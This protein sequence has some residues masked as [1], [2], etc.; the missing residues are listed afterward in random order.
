MFVLKMKINN[1][2][3]IRLAKIFEEF[4]KND[5]RFELVAKRTSA[6][7]CFRLKDQS[8]EM[9]EKLMNAVNATG[10]LFFTHTSLLI[11]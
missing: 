1:F 2:Q 8:N 5:N 9:N 4:V 11:Y 7:V 3:N 6:L 10:K